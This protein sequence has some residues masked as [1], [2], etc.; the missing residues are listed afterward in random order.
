[1]RAAL[2]A[3]LPLF[4]ACGDASSD[5]PS[6]TDAGA[7]AGEAT[8][9][10][11]F[12]VDWTLTPDPP[13]VGDATMKMTIVSADGEPALGAAILVEPFMPSMGHG[14]S[15]APLTTEDEGGAGAYTSTWAWSMGG[16]WEVTVSVGAQGLSDTLVLPFDVQ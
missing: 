8:V 1:M 12:F 14:T 2:L 13:V 5:E 3:L 6:D 10:G 15:D 16:A 4:A 11:H 7:P 9:D